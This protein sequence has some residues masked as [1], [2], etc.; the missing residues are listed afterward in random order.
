MKS[1]EQ[2]IK[3]A[4]WDYNSPDSIKFKT[5]NGE[6][7]SLDWCCRHAYAFIYSTKLNK[8]LI[9]KEA[10][11]HCSILYTEYNDNE[12]KEFDD[13]YDVVNNKDGIYSLRFADNFFKYYG[14]DDWKNQNKDINDRFKLGRFWVYEETLYM[15]WWD[16]LTSS[17]F[18]KY[19]KELLNFIKT[20]TSHV[21]KKI[22]YMTNTGRLIKYNPNKKSKESIATD[23][24][25]Q[26]MK[27][28]QAIHLANQKEKDKF[29][30]E[31]KRKRDSNNQK[32][33]YN[34]TKSKTEAEYRSIRYQGD[35]LIDTE[36]NRI[37]E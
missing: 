33:K 15:T 3:E 9:S 19:N 10:G 13:L 27:L 1:L 12:L 28:Q 11:N 14:Y 20:E 31:F 6:I 37:N 4:Y 5:K 26:I 36:K 18:D 2:H 24:R 29:F 30:K 8:F 21:F 25:K 35:S 34:Y 16:Q 7:G 22:Y 23:D 17:E 32:T